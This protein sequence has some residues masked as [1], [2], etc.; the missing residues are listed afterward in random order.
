VAALFPSCRETAPRAGPESEATGTKA[1]GDVKEEEEEEEE[2]DGSE[3]PAPAAAKGGDGEDGTP[4]GRGACAWRV[5][6]RM[7]IADVLKL[8]GGGAGLQNRTPLNGRS[9]VCCLDPLCLP[10]CHRR[11]PGPGNHAGVLHRPEVFSHLPLAGT[12]KRRQPRTPNSGGPTAA[13][14]ARE[15]YGCRLSPPMA[16]HRPNTSGLHRAGPE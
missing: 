1:K 13:A 14:G 12:P 11:H 10:A 7:L 4:K 16:G 3:P 8:R 5:D 6:V 2:G 15:A 9:P